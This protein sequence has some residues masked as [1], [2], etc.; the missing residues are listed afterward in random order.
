ML[1]SALNKSLFF[2]GIPERW[3][4][5]SE[6]P[7]C[8][9]TPVFMGVSSDFLRDEGLFAKTFSLFPYDCHKRHKFIPNLGTFHSQPG[10]KSFPSWEYPP[11][12]CFWEQ[13]CGV[14]DVQCVQVV[15]RPLCSGAFAMRLQLIR[16]FVMRETFSISSY[17]YTKLFL[18]TTNDL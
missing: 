17:D 5:D 6:N 18:S 1:K 14:V 8:L 13:I 11:K 9:A 15:F 10:N 12:L 2:W 4:R 3:L 7:S 16:A